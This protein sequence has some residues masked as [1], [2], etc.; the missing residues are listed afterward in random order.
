MTSIFAA[1]FAKSKCEWQ[2]DKP[3]AA[4][5]RR[6]QRHRQCIVGRLQWWQVDFCLPAAASLLQAAN[7]KD[8]R[9][10]QT[11]PLAADALPGSSLSGPVGGREEARDLLVS[12]RAPCLLANSRPAQYIIP[13]FFRCNKRCDLGPRDL[14]VREPGHGRA[15]P[16]HRALLTEG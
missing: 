15:G 14:L 3:V 6:Q 16:A 11:P 10:Q 7:P 5:S 1:I 9:S 2:E 4:A 8:S 12:R 13:T